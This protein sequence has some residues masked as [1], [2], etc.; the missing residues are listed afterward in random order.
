MK[1]KRDYVATKRDTL[2]LVPI[3]AWYGNGRKAGWFS[4]WL[5]ACYDPETE[6]YQSVCRVMSGLTDEFYKRK[7]EEYSHTHLLDGKPMYY[8][9]NESCS[10]W[11][12][13]SE[14]WEI[15]GADL[16]LSQVHKAATGMVNGTEEDR[17]ISLRFPRF[18]RERLD[19]STD[20]A[21]CSEQIRSL[22][23]AQTRREDL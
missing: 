1:L 3:G 2:D 19:K 15:C 8:E 9:T 4:P 12:N 10:V 11:F 7:T 23:V 13:A 6:C 5:M 14:V 18:L 16:T 22:F 17:G 20:D 21:T